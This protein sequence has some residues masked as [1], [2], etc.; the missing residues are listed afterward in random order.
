MDWTKK[1]R[2]SYMLSSRNMPTQQRCQKKSTLKI[3]KKVTKK[4]TNI[5]KQAQLTIPASDKVNFIQKL[6]RREQKEYYILIKGAIHQ[7]DRMIVNI[8]TL[9]IGAPKFL[10]Q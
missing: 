10:K 5:N 2:T 9:N 8:C 4:M 6:I 1:L 3:S 7:E